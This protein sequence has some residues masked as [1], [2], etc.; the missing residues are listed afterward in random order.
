[1]TDHS[2]LIAAGVVPMSEHVERF[3]RYLETETV[4]VLVD[5]R[6][7]MGNGCV[8]HDSS[9]FPDD[10]AKALVADRKAQS[11]SLSE[12]G[13]EIERLRAALGKVEHWAESRCPCSNEEPNPCPLCG[14]SVENLEAC[15]S[16]E[17][18]LPRDLLE[19]IRS[20]RRRAR[21]Q[22]LENG[23][24]R[25]ADA[26]NNPADLSSLRKGAEVAVKP[27]EWDLSGMARGYPAKAVSIFGNYTAW[28]IE[29]GFWMPPEAHCGRRA[30]VGLQSAL[31]A[32][33]LD[34]ETRIRSALVSGS[35]EDG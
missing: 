16:A 31:D 22:A 27:L 30:G 15:K 19:T 24:A 35:R 14:A 6:R 10:V 34:F 4:R 8:Y 5:K 26:T 1:M 11:L 33:Q 13:E 21:S 25:L 28:E 3:W 9:S 12:A 17:N 20:A 7:E 29:D 23:P 18:T 32:A 2:D